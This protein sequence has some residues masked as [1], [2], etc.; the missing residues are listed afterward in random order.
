VSRAW[1]LA[2][3]KLTA[4]LACCGL[5]T[6]RL[7]L[8]VHELVGHG[9][10]A[11]AAGGEVTDVW[12]FYFAGGWIRFHAPGGELAIAL[13][14]I[15]VEVVV[16]AALAVAARG[17]GLGA[18]IVRAIGCALVIH[19]AWYLAVGTFHGFGDGVR[20]HRALGD[21]AWLVAVPA[22]AV[23]CAAA[24]IGARVVLGPLAS[25][26]PGGRR[27]RLAGAALAIAVAGGLQLG[28]AAGEVAVRRDAAYAAIMRP[29]RER[30]IARELAAWDE[31][32]R[33]AGAAPT[34]AARAAMEATLARAHRTFPFAYV[35]G[36]CTLLAIALGA[37][38][39][40]TSPPAVLAPRL[41]VVAGALA[42]G[43][44]ALVI[45]LDAAFA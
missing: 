20:L 39:S 40:R 32:Q 1:P 15:V 3:T 35:L 28:A 33:R 5:A 41:L 29:E 44:I 11:I 13:G 14:G 26:I 4:L 24:F 19:A 38:R 25:T 42:A 30:V 23:A 9:G 45:A 27:A 8:V 36:A 7:G 31:A 22:G 6:S 12:L 18:R 2:V 16:G 10:A 43:S 17:D 34:D 21:R 37:A